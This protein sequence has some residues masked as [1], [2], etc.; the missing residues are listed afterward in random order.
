MLE[1]SKDVRRKDGIASTCRVCFKSLSSEYYKKNSEKIKNRIQEY[2]RLNPAK[3]KQFMKINHLRTSYNLSLIDFE[4][5]SER[6]GNVCRCCNIHVSELKKGLFVDHCH[7]TGVVRG[8]LCQKCNM[9][10]GLFN[11]D[12]H[13]LIEASKYLKEVTNEQVS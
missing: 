13:L 8:L 5:L 3:V 11:D 6:Q 1:F 9:G 10:L 2:K 12:P 7:K 4:K